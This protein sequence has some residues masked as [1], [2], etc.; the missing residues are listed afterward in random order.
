MK[1][2]KIIAK[3]NISFL[4][5]FRVEFYKPFNDDLDLNDNERWSLIPCSFTIKIE[6][7]KT[8]EQFKKELEKKAINKWYEKGAKN[9]VTNKHSICL[10]VAKDIE[11]TNHTY[12]DINNN[13]HGFIQYNKIKNINY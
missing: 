8:D 2:F 13:I 10:W 3:E 5:P 4:T 6:G 7:D 9:Y 1:W 11:D 12:P